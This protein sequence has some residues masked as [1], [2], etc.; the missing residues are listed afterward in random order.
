MADQKYDQ[1]LFKELRMVQ[2]N[3]SHVFR[4]GDETTHCLT[5]TP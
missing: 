4:V 5:V 2:F 3:Y 1:L